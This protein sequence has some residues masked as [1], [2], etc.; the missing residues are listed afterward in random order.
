MKFSYLILFLGTTFL[1]AQNGQA[2]MNQDSTQKATTSQKNSGAMEIKHK[3]IPLHKIDREDVH[4]R[5]PEAKEK[6]AM[7]KG[8]GCSFMGSCY[9][10]NSSPKKAPH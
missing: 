9:Q 5:H 4:A 1:W 8:M 10:G 7:K 3:E 6:K 2:V